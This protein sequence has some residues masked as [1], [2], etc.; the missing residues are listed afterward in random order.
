MAVGY[1]QGMRVRVLFFG[2]LRD[3]AGSRDEEI[4]VVK[5]ATVAVL[6]N[7]YKERMPLFGWDSIAVA[8]N[9]EYAKSGD[10][11]RDGDEVALL[12]PV[13]G[14]AAGRHTPGAKAP[15]KTF[16]A[17]RPKAEALGYL[18]ARSQPLLKAGAATDPSTS[19]RFAQDDTWGMVWG[20]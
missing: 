9:Q 18:D 15:F 14:G 19:L 13:S 4:E 8:V 7:V 17:E 12:P 3:M 16:V 6:L 11:L 2:V 1:A 20:L 5:G 10:V